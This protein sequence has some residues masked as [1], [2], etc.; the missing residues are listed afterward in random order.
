VAGHSPTAR[1]ISALLLLASG[2]IVTACGPGQAAAIQTRDQQVQV[3]GPKRITAAI[4]AAPASLV[5]L[6]TQRG[7]ALRGLDDI[8]QLTHAGLSYIKADGTRA[9]QLA[10]E[11]PSIENG[12]WKILPDRR[13]E[14]TW[15]IKPGASW[16]DGVPLTSD[17]LLFATVVEQDRE[18][19][20]QA[21][22]EY[23]LIESIQAPDAHT[24]TVVW[25]RPYSDADAL[26]SYNTAG[27]PLPKHLLEKPYAEDRASF[28][29]LPYW[30]DE[31]LG[32]GAFRLVEWASDSHT[33][34]R[35][36]DHPAE[37]RRDR[38]QVHPG[39]QRY[40]RQCARR[41]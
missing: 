8:E 12:L 21:Y 13:M 10:D 22:A 36:F 15:R 23:G 9:A 34:L 20:I 18:L 11:V 29:A 7:G 28:L 5:L 30:T 38:G 17:D 33:T 25:K 16:Q 31:F 1:L 14:T 41:R 6:K 2:L 39:Q 40:T 35:A 3:A 19:E 32:A 37:D 27:I 24:I 26:F 4:R